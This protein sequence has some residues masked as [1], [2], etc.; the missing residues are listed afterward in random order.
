MKRHK[1]NQVDFLKI[2]TE[3]YEYKVLNGAIN[4]LKKRKI[5]HLMLEKQLSNMYLNYSFEKI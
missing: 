1:I 5:R 3:G 2:D 4:S